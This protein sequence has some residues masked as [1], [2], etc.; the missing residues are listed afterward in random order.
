LRCLWGAWR[1]LGVGGDSR[2]IKG[3]D[4]DGTGWGLG[5]ESV[6]GGEVS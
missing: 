4:G 3:L 1:M 5:V 6:V 2:W